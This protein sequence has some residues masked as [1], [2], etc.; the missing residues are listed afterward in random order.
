MIP[1]PSEAPWLIL[2]TL[3]AGGWT[4]SIAGGGLGPGVVIR[5]TRTFAGSE[6]VETI[7][8]EVLLRRRGDIDLEAEE[9]GDSVAAVALVLATTCARLVCDAEHQANGNQP[10]PA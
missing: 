5:A 2:D 9:S 4:I 3:A 7:G 1:D 8:G 10:A 6:Q